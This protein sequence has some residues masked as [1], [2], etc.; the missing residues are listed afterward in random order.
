MPI[1]A[2]YKENKSRSSG[3]EEIFLH[4]EYAFYT[5]KTSELVDQEILVTNVTFP[6]GSTKK[7]STTG[8]GS[9]SFF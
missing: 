2:S 8:V 6:T 4:L 5:K 1:A 9:P 3:L 7:Q